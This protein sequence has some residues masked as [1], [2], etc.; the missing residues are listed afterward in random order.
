MYQ[1]ELVLSAQLALLTELALSVQLVLLTEL[2]LSVQL[3]LLT[4][5]VHWAPATR[6][7]ALA[8]S[9]QLA[10]LKI[11]ADSPLKKLIL[12]LQLALLNSHTQGVTFN[13]PIKQ[14]DTTYNSA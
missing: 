7:K 13:N 2:V 3:V 14:K 11:G 8:L 5:L 9:V 10:L 6:Q 4:K 12:P 1:V